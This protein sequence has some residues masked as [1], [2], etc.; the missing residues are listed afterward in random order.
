M[1]QKQNWTLLDYYLGQ[2]EID[3]ILEIEPIWTVILFFRFGTISL[4][5]VANWVKFGDKTESSRC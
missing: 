2:W 1:K 4:S 3:E 5:L